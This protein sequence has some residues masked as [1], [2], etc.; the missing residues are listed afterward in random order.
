MS[1]K[2]AG[3]G[4]GW[5]GDLVFS[6]SANRR[7]SWRILNPPVGQSFFEVRTRWIL[8][9]WVGSSS[10]GLRRPNPK[11]LASRQ[12][13]LTCCRSIIQ[14]PG[15]SGHC[16]LCQSVLKHLRHAGSVM[17][18]VKERG[19]WQ[20]VLRT[21]FYYKCFVSQSF[22]QCFS[23]RRSTSLAEYF[24]HDDKRKHM[25]SHWETFFSLFFN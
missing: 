4:S 6:F 18:S 15:V 14:K 11:R 19:S 9:D 2:N 21:W 1:R 16:M 22:L 5:G 8:S 25:C 20:N 3:W 7:G 13:F 10:E 17:K 12:L 23:W 24:T